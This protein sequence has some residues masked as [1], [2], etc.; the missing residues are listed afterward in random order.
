MSKYRLD[1]PQLANRVPE[2]T[3]G[4]FA[5][6]VP[7][8]KGESRSL[9]LAFLALL[10]N[11][12]LMLLGPWLVG[13][14]IDLHVVPGDYPGLLRA[15]I[16]LLFTYV[17]MLA[18]GYLQMR[19]MGSIGQRV[20]FALR[21]RI[22]S[23]LQE[24]PVSFFGQNK[25]GD[26]IARISGDA[27]ALNEFF[28]YQLMQFVGQ[29]ILIIG[30]AIALVLLDWRIG[31]VALIPGVVLVGISYLL[32]PWSQKRNRQ[33]REALGGL[34][35]DIAESLANFK[36]IVSFG[37]QDYF[38]ARFGAVN[39]KT[40]D[41]AMAAG[42]A[43]ALFQPIYTLAGSLGLLVVLAYGISLVSQGALTIGV[44]IAALAYAP[45]LYDPVRQIGAMWMSLQTALA[46]WDRI[47]PLLALETDLD[48]LPVDEGAKGNE[49]FFAFRDVSFRYEDGAQVLN[50]VSFS[51]ERGKS[52]ALV[53]PTGGGKT[54]TASLMARLFDP[55]DGTVVL[56]GRDLRTWTAAERTAKIGFIL[57]EPFLF[58]GT[59]QDNLL[60]GNDALQ[61]LRTDE[62]ENELRARGLEELLA[63]FDQGLATPAGDA[64]SLGQRQLLAFMRAV[65]R[66]PELLI[67]DEATANVDTITEGQLE[68]VLRKLPAGTTLVT[69]AHRLNTIEA[70]DQIFFVNGGHVTPAGSLEQAVDMLLHGKRSS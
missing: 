33:S 43:N 6:L 64:L 31:L 44:L 11:S 58:S 53:G 45:R 21:N 32:G 57:Q 2:S 36:V 9:W 52:Y 3:L 47:T 37:R 70:A 8:L 23:K 67:L 29:V 28:A 10:V 63:R 30:A 20:L 46:A 49:P 17:A 5:K 12:G 48:V 60:Y 59:V 68:T 35:G 22:F 16:V 65:L 15:G 14:A 13:R 66:K 7:L 25:A 27:Q 18:F 40:Y 56:E 26:L 41:S 54:T 1:T 24:L 51:L 4:A 61:G 50:D 34:S 69:I 62:L 39:E 19:T 55:T 42:Y 38:R